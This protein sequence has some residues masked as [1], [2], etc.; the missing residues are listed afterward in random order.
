MVDVRLG[1]LKKEET[2]VVNE[3]CTAVE[4]KKRGDV[5]PTGIMNELGGVKLALLDPRALLVLCKVLHRW[6]QS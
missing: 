4:V 1:T 5:F 2:V 6:G 3:L